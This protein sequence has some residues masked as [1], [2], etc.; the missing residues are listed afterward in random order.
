M[1]C[2]HPV[3]PPPSQSAQLLCFFKCV[4]CPPDVVPADWVDA[5]AA[6]RE[7]A[8]VCKKTDALLPPRSYYLQRRGHV[9][10]GFDHYCV[11]I[12]MPIGISNRRYFIQFL[13]YSSLLCFWG[14]G[15]SVYAISHKWSVPSLSDE[16]ASKITMWATAAIKLSYLSPAL[17]SV[18]RLFGLGMHSDFAFELFVTGLDVL[19]GVTLGGFCSFQCWLVLRNRSTLA[20]GNA[21]YDVGRRLNWQQQMGVRVAAWLLPLSTRGASDGLHYP[22]N[23]DQL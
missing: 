18:L 21:K 1:P 6:G 22:L 12:G 9:V 8:E 16:E 4:L 3:I 5:A 7:V 17:A 13:L 19:G 11:W 2:Q 23:P 10:L 14:G 15:M 20:P